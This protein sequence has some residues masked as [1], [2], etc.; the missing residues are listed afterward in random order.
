[1]V[2]K[3]TSEYK[4]RR[5]NQ[6]SQR[7]QQTQP[8]P[9]A[10][11]SLRSHPRYRSRTNATHATEFGIFPVPTP[12]VFSYG[13]FDMHKEGNVDTMTLVGIT[14]AKSVKTT[15]GTDTETN[16]QSFENLEKM[17]NRQEHP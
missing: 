13:V 10:I 9:P 5:W 16:G 6:Q 2:S 1:M 8:N 14:F 11:G 17:E 4:E 7:H 15:L 12:F 3:G